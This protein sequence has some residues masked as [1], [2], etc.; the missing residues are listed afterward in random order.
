MGIGEGDRVDLPGVQFKVNFKTYSGYLN[1]NDNGTWQMHYMLTES[2]SSPSN[3]PLLV[4]FNGGPGCSSLL[5][6][7]EELGSFY[8]NFDGATLYENVYAWNAKANVLYLESPIGVGFSYDTTQDAYINA[9]D[10]QTA[11]QN[12]AALKDFFSRVQPQY[13]NRTFYLTGESYA[14]IYIPMLSQRVVEGISRGDFPNNKFQGAAIGNGFMNVPYL[15]NSLVL[16]SAYHGRVSLD[17]WDKIKVAC[18]TGSETDVEKYDFT[19]FMTSKNGMDYYGDSSECG[20]L[21]APLISND[22]YGSIQ[23]IL[24]LPVLPF[25]FFG[26]FYD[27]YNYYQDCYQ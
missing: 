8:V 11:A 3:D 7:F 12:Y 6:L 26:Y 10:D 22:G 21:I 18:K 5:G 1:A 16:W 20:K 23:V 17:D 13:N 9:N 24:V 4:W 15:M 27:Q 14:G 25:R 19:R 2:R